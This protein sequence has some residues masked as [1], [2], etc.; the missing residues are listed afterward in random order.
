MEIKARGRRRGSKNYAKEFRT[1]VVAET[2][3]P[4]RSLA[5]VARSHGLNANLVSK[6]RRDQER[7]AASAS[8]PAEL[9]LPKRWHRR[10]CRS[11]LDR[12]GSSSNV[13][14]CAC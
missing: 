11:R 1:Q 14:A 8:E 6:W 12:P 4:A 13:G 5:E 9:F 2:L 7:A 3:D 10:R